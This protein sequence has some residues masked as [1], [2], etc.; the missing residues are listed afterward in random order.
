MYKLVAVEAC[1]G[2]ITPKIKISENEEKIT[3]PGFK[4]LYRIY[5]KNSHQAI[6]D[7]ITMHDEK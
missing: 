3:N 2:I 1:D 7:L 4:K 5:D 6:A